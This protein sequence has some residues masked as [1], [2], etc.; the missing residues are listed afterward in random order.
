MPLIA[1]RACNVLFN[2]HCAYGTL[3]YDGTLALRI[4]KHKNDSERKGH[5]PA[6]G[7][8]INPDLDLVHQLRTWMRYN[9]IEVHSHCTASPGAQCKHCPPPVSKLAIGPLASHITSTDPMSAQTV[10]HCVR[11]M[12]ALCNGNPKNYS[13]I[14]AH[15]GGLTTAISAGVPEEIVFLQSGHGQTRA[16]RTY[17]HL[18][19]PDRLLD[20][21]RA[22][23]L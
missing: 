17:M 4:V 6:V 11:R 1:P 7:R 5:C 18:Q 21:F 19:D 8:P 12:A 15:K 13:G 9:D 3:G 16:A 22:F 10:R 20:T 23:G 2:S 14:S